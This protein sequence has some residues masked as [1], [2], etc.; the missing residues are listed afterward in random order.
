MNAARAIVTPD[1]DGSINQSRV[2][3]VDADLIATCEAA[4][5]LEEQALAVY[6]GSGRPED[7]YERDRI[8]NE[9]CRRIGPAKAGLL[10]KVSELNAQTLDGLKAKARLYVTFD[11]TLF[12]LTDLG[13]YGDVVRS[14]V[15]DLA[16]DYD[17]IAAIPRREVAP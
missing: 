1:P 8:S 10:D 7:D 11:P 12:H 13:S 3:E 16:G 15:R 9:V 5:L 17:P 4:R 2:A 6:Y 14:I